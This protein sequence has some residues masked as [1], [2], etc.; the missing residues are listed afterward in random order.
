MNLVSVAYGS[1]VAISTCLNCVDCWMFFDRMKQLRVYSLVLFANFE[2]L[3]VS[4]TSV[5]VMSFE[6]FVDW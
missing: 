6:D 3:F 4:S 5:G 2:M 1:V